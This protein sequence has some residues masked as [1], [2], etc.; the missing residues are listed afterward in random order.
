M[1]KIAPRS[2]PLA[3]FLIFALF[4]AT[5]LSGE[6]ILRVLTWTDYLE[7][8]VVS[9]FQR[10]F[11]C[12][13]AVDIFAENDDMS[14]LLQLGM[15]EYDLIIP[16]QFVADILWQR[17]MLLELTPDL[18]PNRKNLDPEVVETAKENGDWKYAVPYTRVV[19]GI[20]YNR[21][22]VRDGGRS[23]GIFSRKDLAGK[24]A[25][26]DDMRVTLAAA[27]L[28]LGHDPNTTKADEIRAAADQVI[29]WQQNGVRF[30]VDQSKFGLA[31]GEFEVVHAYNG[32]I[33][34][35]M[36]DN[37]DIEFAVPREG[38]TLNLDS[39]VIPVVAYR[40]DLA[41]AFI[42]FLLDVDNARQNMEGILYAMPIPAALEGL[43]ESL[44]GS[45]FFTISGE[46]LRRCHR[47]RDLGEDNVKYRREWERVKGGEP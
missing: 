12:R 31:S 37:P 25:M 20:G 19:S 40:P 14:S 30:D 44:R 36:M 10:E 11:A 5:A 2:L 13:V 39:F 3:L 26:L 4:A 1:P 35:A 18:I 22:L 9:R 15:V 41:H 42:N 16:S 38:A 17:G 45:P 47:L 28:F 46:V 29:K 34:L 21:W 23:W 6:K 33:G 43:D 8:A 24:M 7:P 32:D 27:L